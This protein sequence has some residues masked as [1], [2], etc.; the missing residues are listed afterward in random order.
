MIY[1]QRDNICDIRVL[2]T[3][4][5]VLRKHVLQLNT[6]LTNCISGFCG[7]C[8]LVLDFSIHCAA[9]NPRY[10][11]SEAVFNLVGNIFTS[12]VRLERGGVG[13]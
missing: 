6:F 2:F 5:A 4:R 13:K 11:P 9:I 7:P 12:A 8:E 3:G 10:L 1:N